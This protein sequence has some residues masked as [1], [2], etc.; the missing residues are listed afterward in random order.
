MVG[1]SL[2]LSHGCHHAPGEILAAVTEGEQTHTEAEGRGDQSGELRG[3]NTR[4]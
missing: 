4:Q 3:E 2:G 1:G